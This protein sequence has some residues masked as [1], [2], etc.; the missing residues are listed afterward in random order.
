MAIDLVL[1][2]TSRDWSCGSLLLPSAQQRA[3]FAK[4]DDVRYDVRRA[5]RGAMAGLLSLSAALGLVALSGIYRTSRGGND[6]W[7]R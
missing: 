6:R 2:R 5:G 3:L 1:G 7:H 4:V